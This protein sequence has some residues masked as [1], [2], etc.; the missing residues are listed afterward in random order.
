GIELL[1]V[2][3]IESDRWH[4]AVK[5][6]LVYTKKAMIYSL[7]ATVITTDELVSRTR[8]QVVPVDL[9]IYIAQISYDFGA[10]S[11]TLAKYL[12]TWIAKA[13]SFLGETVEIDL[14]QPDLR[15]KFAGV[16]LPCNDLR[17]KLTINRTH[18]LKYLAPTEY[19][20]VRDHVRGTALPLHLTLTGPS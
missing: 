12:R 1:T 10:T 6:P 9:D 15:L 7:D 2:E 11:T 20:Q 16:W 18:Y 17:I 13:G 4:A 19:S 3:D 14:L 5:I 8:T